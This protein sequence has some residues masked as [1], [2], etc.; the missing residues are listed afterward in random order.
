MLSPAFSTVLLAQAI[1]SCYLPDSEGNIK[2]ALPEGVKVDMIKE[3]IQ[4]ITFTSEYTSEIFSIL[5]DACVEDLD[6][7]SFIM[8]VFNC[9]LIRENSF[10]FSAAEDYLKARKII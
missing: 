6:F 2:K 10:T 9:D 3:T 5:V 4:K 1:S 7:D 8:S